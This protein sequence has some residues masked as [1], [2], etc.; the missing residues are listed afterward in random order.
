MH[1]EYDSTDSA[2]NSILDC[3]KCPTSSD[4]SRKRKLQT[5]PPKGRKRGKG[6]VAAEPS[7]SPS[8]RVREFPEEKLSNVMGKLFCIA[9]RENLSVKKSVI[10][11]HIKS[12]K[13][14]AGKARMAMKEKK[15][16]DIADMLSKYDNTVHPV[17]ET[18]SESV[19]VYRVRVLKTFL[20]AGVKAG[21]PLGKLDVFRE[22]LEENAFRLCDSSIMRE[23][24]PFVRK[25][26]QVDL[27][28]EINGKY[29]SVILMELPMCAKLW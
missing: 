1:E 4:L 14:N 11:Q 8:E 17:G 13:H 20:K 25:Q 19:R 21:V 12:A 29:I 16:R 3:L 10:S 28:E 24:I 18:L 22:L 26:V 2:V 7:V 6:E 15:E 5:N 27:M 9:C 23:L